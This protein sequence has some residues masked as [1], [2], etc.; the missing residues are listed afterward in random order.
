MDNEIR[1][2]RVVIDSERLLVR[3]GHICWYLRKKSL[4]SDD[5]FSVKGF[6]EALETI[7][8]LKRE[9]RKELRAAATLEIQENQESNGQARRDAAGCLDEKPERIECVVVRKEGRKGCIRHN[10]LITAQYAVS[11]RFIIIDIRILISCTV[12]SRHRFG[13][14]WQSAG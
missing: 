12:C 6:S 10:K 3:L 13:F 5:A 1:P 8:T 14:C 9:V 11:I 7:W 2:Y 4:R